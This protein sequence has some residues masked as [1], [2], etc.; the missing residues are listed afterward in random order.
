MIID[1]VEKTILPGVLEIVP[2][3]FE[4][5][6]GHFFEF[7]N[8]DAFKKHEIPYRYVQDNQSFSKKNILRGL[9]YQLKYP[10]GKLVRVVQGEVY[11]VAVDIRSSSPTFGKSFGRGIIR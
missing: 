8:K 3:I 6:R 4:D 10:Q 5:S 7:Y 2:K 9:H 11:D 1:K